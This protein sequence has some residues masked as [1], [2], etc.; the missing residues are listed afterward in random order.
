MTGGTTPDKRAPHLAVRPAKASTDR[1]RLLSRIAVVLVLVALTLLLNNP[2]LRFERVAPGFVNLPD[3][4]SAPADLPARG[5]LVW[6]PVPEGFLLRAEDNRWAF[7]RWEQPS[8][9]G[10]DKVRVIG[11][12]S[13]GNVSPEVG[14][15]KDARLVVVQP[16]DNAPYRR[17]VAR[18]STPV[19]AQNFDRIMTIPDQT[20]PLWI[21]LVLTPVSGEILLHRLTVDGLETRAAV[22]GLRWLLLAV[23]IGLV[24]VTLWRLAHPMSPP[25]RS[26]FWIVL[27][28]LLAGILAPPELLS[29]GRDL[30]WSLLFL[31]PAIESSFDINAVGHFALFCALAVIVFQG[32]PELGWM[33]LAGLLIA[34]AGATELM[35]LLVD[36]RHADWQD[37][38]VDLAG[39]GA[40]ALVVTLARRVGSFRAGA[41]MRSREP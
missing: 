14:P 1:I 13:I 16:D 5:R 30:L 9:H 22:E 20:R 17:A 31:D 18:W 19:I 40:A 7:V 4:V 3:G 39:I 28:L 2:A 25:L 26:R 32:R 24:L 29:G 36:G 11:E 15:G 41:H 10:L 21:E 38:A 37:I 34:F 12:V 35:Q 6:E 8:P 27:A 23:W 33:H